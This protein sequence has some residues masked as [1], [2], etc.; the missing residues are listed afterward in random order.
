[1][2]IRGIFDNIEIK[3][4]CL[5]LAIVM[6]LYVSK[7]AGLIE[8]VAAPISHDDQGRITFREV[9]IKL[10]ALEEQKLVSL[11]KQWKASPSEIS[12]EVKSMAAEVEMS[13]FRVGVKLT[14]EDRE[15]KKECRITL[16]VENVVIPDGLTFV[17]AEPNEIRIT[18]L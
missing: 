10:V 15:G 4:I 16:T 14:P 8:W 6:W 13:N 17:K 12:L 3:V 9:P 18:P 5:L 7:G 11:E 2:K 1:M